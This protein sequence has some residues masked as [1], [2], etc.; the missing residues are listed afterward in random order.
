MV[1]PNWEECVS[2]YDNVRI[3]A[4]SEWNE[5]SQKAA[6]E[7]AK[8]TLLKEIALRGFQMIPFTTES[9]EAF[10]HRFLQEVESWSAEFPH[11][12]KVLKVQI[13]IF[14]RG[15]L[16]M[17]SPEPK[18]VKV[19]HHYLQREFARGFAGV[20]SKIFASVRGKASAGGTPWSVPLN[21]GE[22]LKKFGF[23]NHLY[24]VPSL[25]AYRAMWEEWF[26]EVENATA[27]VRKLFAQPD[28][29][30]ELT[31]DQEALLALYLAV[32]AIRSPYA[33][34]EAEGIVLTPGHDLDSLAGG[35]QHVIRRVLAVTSFRLLQEL[36]SSKWILC[37][38]IEGSRFISGDDPGSAFFKHGKPMA[39]IP[40]SKFWCLTV[41]RDPIP[42]LQT[43]LPAA[44]RS[45]F[46]MRPPEVL[47]TNAT[48][49]HFD[50][51]RFIIG[52]SE[53]LLKDAQSYQGTL[54][55]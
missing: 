54:L 7:P 2:T 11:R 26:C 9:A 47:Q 34:A 12:V 17:F 10:H 53:Q 38:A 1:P 36:L 20:D 18:D 49:A 31:R 32:Q 5:L 41:F 42:E 15:M 27:Q 16:R 50:A 30:G 35:S 19:K 37:R 25:G 3:E 33:K 52:S 21:A 45:Y 22:D 24:D 44:H 4:L 29:A 13:D 8:F 55:Y 28:W 51:P 40:L 48:V 6:S 14:E 23:E 43:G 39:W 46:P